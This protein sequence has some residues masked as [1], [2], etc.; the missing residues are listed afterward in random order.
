ML[1]R[2]ARWAN[3]GAWHGGYVG[4]LSGLTNLSIQVGSLCRV[5]AYLVY[6]FGLRAPSTSLFSRG[7]STAQYKLGLELL[8]GR[9]RAGNKVG[10]VCLIRRVQA[11]NQGARSASFPIEVVSAHDIGT[12]SLRL[13]VW[14][15][16]LCSDMALVYLLGVAATISV[17]KCNH[18]VCFWHVCLGLQWALER[19]RA[20]LR[21]QDIGSQMIVIVHACMGD[22]MRVNTTTAKNMHHG[23]R[24]V[25]QRLQ[26]PPGF[27][28]AV[29]AQVDYLGDQM[30]HEIGATFHILA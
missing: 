16:R 29:W 8:Q 4:I 18:L 22:S 7:H 15:V 26:S 24:H 14:P 10:W 25:S 17:K 13:M 19:N 23:S 20:I 6:L 21:M 5:V 11:P 12:W 28:P 9:L 1:G 30:N 2:P 3:D 27:A